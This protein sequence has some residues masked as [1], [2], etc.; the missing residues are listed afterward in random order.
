MVLRE[1]LLK[2]A[3]ARLPLRD[4]V[5]SQNTGIPTMIDR[6]D[7]QSVALHARRALS[8]DTGPVLETIVNQRVYVGLWVCADA[9]G[10]FWEIDVNL[11]KDTAWLEDGITRGD[12]LFRVY[13]ENLDDAMTAYHGQVLANTTFDATTTP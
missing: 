12:E 9:Q 10:T 3:E 11:M 2:P 8:C 4:D 6:N 7:S 13:R 1:S 5:T